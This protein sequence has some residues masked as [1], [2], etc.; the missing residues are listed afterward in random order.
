MEGGSE[1]YGRGF[2]G[3]ERPE[4]KYIDREDYNKFKDEYLAVWEPLIR[5]SYPGEIRA[6]SSADDKGKRFRYPGDDDLE[7][8]YEEYRDPI[9]ALNVNSK[10]LFTM[11]HRKKKG[12][13]DKWKGASLKVTRTIKKRPK[14]R[15]TKKDKKGKKKATK[16]RKK[17]TKSFFGSLPF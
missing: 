9:R 16:K 10:R 12:I 1:G 17:S 5:I 15:K 2:E 14:A 8:L 3:E 6:T 7:E 4:D 13:Q 11:I